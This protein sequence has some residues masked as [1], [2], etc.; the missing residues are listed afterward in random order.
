MVYYYQVI[1]YILQQDP[2]MTAYVMHH[3]LYYPLFQLLI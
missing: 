1:K 3:T 2:R